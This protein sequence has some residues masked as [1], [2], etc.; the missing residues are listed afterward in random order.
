MGSWAPE[1]GAKHKATASQLRNIARGTKLPRIILL[2]IRSMSPPNC[3]HTTGTIG[4]LSSSVRILI[5]AFSSSSKSLLTAENKAS[6][7][8]KTHEHQKHIIPF[9]GMRAPL[10]FQ[11][12]YIS[13][14][15][16]ANSLDTWVHFFDTSSQILT[17]FNL[18]TF[19]YISYILQTAK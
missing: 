19:P 17:L 9:L 15:D 1:R 3:A 14:L 18:E 10:N 7:V 11:L 5:L 2:R 8:N 13:L 16:K 6:T 4:C 12:M